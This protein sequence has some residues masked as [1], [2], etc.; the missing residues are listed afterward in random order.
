MLHYLVFKVQPEYVSVWELFV[1]LPDKFSYG[2]PEKLCF[3]GKRQN[4]EA[5]LQIRD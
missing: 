1:L 4:K 2:A 5:V 3:L